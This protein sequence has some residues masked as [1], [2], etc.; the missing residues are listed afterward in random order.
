M[1]CMGINWYK[2]TV[3]VMRQRRKQ[4]TV[5]K[6]PVEAH[7]LGHPSRPPNTVTM[8]RKYMILAALV[9]AAVC[10]HAGEGP[11]ITHKVPPRGSDR[12][13]PPTPDT[14]FGRKNL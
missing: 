13:S 8:S 1:A 12:R 3:S 5:G 4:L 6:G 7:K 2:T 10:A 9:L 14:Q 11:T